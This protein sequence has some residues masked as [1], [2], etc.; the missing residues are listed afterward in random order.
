MQDPATGRCK[1]GDGRP[2]LIF[3]HKTDMRKLD[4]DRWQIW[5]KKKIRSILHWG[6]QVEY[7]ANSEHNHSI[8]VRPRLRLQKRHP[9]LVGQLHPDR[10]LKVFEDLTIARSDV[11]EEKIYS[12][13]LAGGQ[14]FVSTAL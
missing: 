11:M 2:S 6:C 4:L 7:G 14:R 1:A 3:A 10:F 9:L 5:K 12:I 8:L 13:S